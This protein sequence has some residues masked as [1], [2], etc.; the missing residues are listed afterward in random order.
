VAFQKAG[1]FVMQ[2]KAGQG[3]MAR[4]WAVMDADGTLINLSSP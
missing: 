2:E 4:L 1:K 3:M